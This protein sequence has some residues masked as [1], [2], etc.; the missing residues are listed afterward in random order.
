MR[1]QLA[2]LHA[3][4]RDSGLRRAILLSFTNQA[5]GSGGNFL[6]SLYLARNMSLEQFGIYGICYGACTLYVGVGNAL[7]LTQMTVGMPQRSA[8]QR[9][10]LAGHTL[11]GVLMLGG[12]LLALVLPAAAL[13]ALA[14]RPGAAPLAL[15][16]LTAALMLGSEFFIS[17]AYQRRRE[18]G[19]LLVNGVLMLTLAAGLA[20][21]AW[22]G[23]LPDAGEAL[24]L[25]AAGALLAC[26]L[27]YA[28]APLPLGGARR[29]RADDLHGF[30]QHGR[31]A[32]GGVAVT[33]LQA[34][35]ATYAL[36]VVL[37]PAGAGLANMGRLFISPFSFLLPAIYKVALPRLAELRLRAPR[38]MRQ[39]ATRMTL[40]LTA[41]AALYALLVLGTLDWV[42]PRLLGQAV[43]QLAPLVLCWCLV[44][45]AQVLR[46]G[47]SQL[48]QMQLKFRVLTLMNLPSAAL[49]L[50]AA[51][52]LMRPFAHSGA[53]AGVLAGEVLLAALI[54]K[55][56]VHDHPA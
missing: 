3:A 51:L 35:S 16:A 19:A 10:L 30:W 12:A 38:R 5:L 6:L 23:H 54:W 49:A 55:E 14:G 48:L 44:L 32:L 28:S 18:Q 8:P 20:L 40:A 29:A 37:G 2:R 43:P 21:L 45:V 47:G 34:Q 52:L 1:A 31:W 46:S 36:A 41:L 4:S 27:A 26:L 39:L 13:M 17:H 9:A 11:A 15:A 50:G 22:R 33:W 25:Y 42:A 24:A 7:L 53:V 56:I